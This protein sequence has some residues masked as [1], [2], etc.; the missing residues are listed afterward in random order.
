MQSAKVRESNSKRRKERRGGG[1]K[2]EGEEEGEEREEEEEE[3]S[4]QATPVY[5]ACIVYDLK[6]MESGETFLLSKH[7]NIKSHE[8]Y[9][10]LFNI[11]YLCLAK[12]ID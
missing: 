10:G 7:I 9:I 2:E 3:A 12:G 8:S 11:P 5:I 1:E 6:F 4:K